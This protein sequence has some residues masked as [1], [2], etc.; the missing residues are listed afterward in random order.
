M[1]RS[2]RDIIEKNGRDGGGIR[3][4]KTL[5]RL[6]CAVVAGSRGCGED[7]VGTRDRGCC[8]VLFDAGG[9]IADEVVD[10]EGAVE[11]SSVDP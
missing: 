4:T 2:I 7:M 8:C 3:D 10:G 9:E 1:Q 6:L 11:D 5:L